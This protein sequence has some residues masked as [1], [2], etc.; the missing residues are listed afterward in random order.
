[1]VDRSVLEAALDDTLGSTSFHE[2]GE[3]YEGKVRDN[4]TRGDRRFIVVTD[5]I[6]AFDRVLGTIPFK[7]QVLNRVATYWF[8]K[9]RA[10]APNHVI[11]VP[12][13]NV[14]ECVECEPL[15]VEMVMRGYLAGTTSTSIWVH[16]QKGA[17]SFCGHAL[18]DGMT[19]NQKLPEPLLTPATKAPM[20]EHD[21]SVSR[22]EI[23]AAGKVSAADFDLAA[24][25]AKALFAEGQR[26]AAS[27]GLIMA[28]TKYELGKTRDGRVILIDEIHTPD[29]SR[30]WVAASYEGRLAKG[31]E[32]E[33]LDK[34]YVR[35]W[36]LEQGYTGDGAP[37]PLTDEVRIEAARRYIDACERITGEPFVPDTRPPAARILQNLSDVT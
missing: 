33:G 15:L 2:I 24:S 32:P 26:L 23:L 29:S 34:D 25:Y 30:Y 27:R 28:D 13:P 10:I 19:K 36:L 20:G 16:Y 21:Q 9:T 12:D 3:K 18:P 11:R 37:P 4:Y 8:E 31:L 17:R 35:R 1:M 7:G 5:R 22:E 6:S 14:L